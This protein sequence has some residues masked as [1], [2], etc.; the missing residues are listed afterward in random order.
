MKDMEV[1]VFGVIVHIVN[2]DL[3]GCSLYV[4]IAAIQTVEFSFL[5]LH[6]AK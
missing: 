6:S 5:V 2:H 1:G 4:C 3:Y